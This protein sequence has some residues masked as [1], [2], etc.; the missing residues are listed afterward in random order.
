MADRSL[1]AVLHLVEQLQP[2]LERRERAK[3]ADVVGQLVAQRAPMGDQWRSLA[4]VA[5]EIGELSLSR[6]AI[7]LFVEASGSDPATQYHKALLL[8]ETGDLRN[9]EAIL[10]ALPDDVPSPV[11]MAFS[12]GTTSL[13]L[14]ETDDAR[15]HLERVAGMQPASGSTWLALAMAADLAREPALADRIVAAERGMARSIPTER[16][17]YFYALGKVWAARNEHALAFAAFARGAGLLKSIVAYDRERDRT[18]AREAARGYSAEAIAA[19]A[20]RQREPTARSIFVTG[21]PRSGT[22]LVEQI[23]TSHSEVGDGAEIN[24]LELLAMEVGGRSHAALSRYV[25]GHGVAPAARL[26]RHWLDERFPGPGRIVDK[27][28]VN[29]GRFLGLAAALLP[30]APLIWVTRDPLDRAWSC[31]RTYFIWGNMPWSYDLEDMACHFRLQ[32]QLLE[33]WQQILGD[34]LLVVPLEALI[35]DPDG[36]IR[37]IV[38]HCGLP[39]EPQVFAPHENRRPVTTAS[40]LQVRRPINREGIGSAE[41]YRQFLEPFIEAYHGDSRLLRASP[42]R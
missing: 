34:R 15:L 24:R 31:F 2:A 9:S 29:T 25:D 38:A 17:A 32:D 13:L 35:D 40:M 7:D 37:R 12:R 18:E 5:A 6:E 28:T 19:I 27:T 33:Q 11:A 36:W 20:S 10:R 23:L 16:A 41:P 42:C 4:K 3:I 21:L 30:E 39:E 22:T 1:T 26:W 14:G 8:A